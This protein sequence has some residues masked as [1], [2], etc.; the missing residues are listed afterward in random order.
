MRAKGLGARV[1]V[2]EIDPV[3]A[4]EAVLDG[5]SVMP[6]EQAAPI[7]EIFI[8]VTGNRDI[9][10]LRHFPLMRDGAILCNAGHFDVEVNVKALREAAVSHKVSRENVE[11]FIMPCGKTLHLLGEGRLVNLTCADGHPVEIMDMSFAVQ[12]LCAA[13]LARHRGELAPTLHPVPKEIDSLVAHRKLSA[14]GFE[15]DMLT[16]EQEAYLQLWK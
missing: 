4:I 10:G 12:A 15:I 5:F 14:S 11:S 6:M 16:D 2:T 3:R 8:T 1:I 7:G 9:I 13:Y